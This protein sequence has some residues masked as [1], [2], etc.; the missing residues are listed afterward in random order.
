MILAFC[1]HKY[2]SLEFSVEQGQE[3]NALGML[4]NIYPDEMQ[5][6]RQE[7]YNNMQKHLG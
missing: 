7:M 4:K 1:V 3:E 5:S 6:V 2:D